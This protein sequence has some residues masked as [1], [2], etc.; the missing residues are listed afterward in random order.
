MLLSHVS[1]VNPSVA[2]IA[3]VENVVDGKT[4]IQRFEHFL[5]PFVIDVQVTDEIGVEATF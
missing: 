5:L 4:E 1:A 3:M 2:A